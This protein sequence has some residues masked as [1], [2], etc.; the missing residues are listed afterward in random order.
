MYDLGLELSGGGTLAM[1]TL[2]HWVF[3]HGSGMLSWRWGLLRDRELPVT[4]SGYGSDAVHAS[5]H[6]LDSC[7]PEAAD[8]S[9]TSR[10]EVSEVI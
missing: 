8:T 5:C 4:L 2:T 9:G 6:D 3:C 10:E 1:L 7:S